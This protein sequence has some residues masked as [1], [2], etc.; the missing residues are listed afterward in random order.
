MKMRK[1]YLFILLSVSYILKSQDFHWTKGFHGTNQMFSR[2]ITTDNMGNVYTVGEF[3]GTVDFNGGVGT[4]TLSTANSDVFITKYDNNGNFIW[5]KNF[6]GGSVEEVSIAVDNLNNLYITGGFSGTVDFDP[7]TSINNQISNGGFDIYVVKLNSSGNFIW[8]KKIGGTNNE[9]G[10]DIKVSSSIFI[11]GKYAG[12]VDFDPGSS[13]INMTSLGNNDVFVLKLDLNGNYIWIKSMGGTSEDYGNSIILDAF[14]NVYTTGLFNN[15]ADFNPGA[16]VYNLVSNNIYSTFISKLDANGNFVWAKSVT[17]TGSQNIGTS[18]A[19]DTTGN[20]FIA[21]YFNGTF[22]FDSGA[23]TYNIT[24]APSGGNN[25]FILKLNINGDF[26]WA[27]NLTGYSSTG[28][29]SISINKKGY[30]FLTSSFNGS[31]DFDPSASVYSLT[32]SG[33]WDS[34]VTKLNNNGNFIW[35]KKFNGASND[36]NMAKSIALDDN[37]D[38]FT[39]G[40]FSGTTDFD[41]TPNTVNL[42]SIGFYDTYVVKLSSCTNLSSVKN[43]TTCVNYISPSGN[44][45]WTTSGTYHD[46]IA[47]AFGCDS[48]ITVNLTFD[49]SSA[50]AYTTNNM[51]ATFSITGTGCNTFLW[52]FGNGNTSSINPNPVI[53]YASPGTYGVCLQCNGQPTNCV[54]CINITVPSNTGSGV[55]IEEHQ[56]QTDDLFSPNPTNEI[57]HIKANQIVNKGTIE[58]VNLQGQT[59]Y[60]SNKIEEQ[61]NLSNQAKGVYFIQLVTEQNTFTKKII[62]Q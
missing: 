33:T 18:L 5:A 54:K 9:K 34:Y 61:I 42:T 24:S 57:I 31:V 48:T 7:G 11:T 32:S 20:L 35:A 29:N 23:G 60:K 16:S 30:L 27:K 4:T 53:T 51:V 25:A 37:G 49:N 3:F 38:I 41:P 15:T 36:V 1:I 10:L 47:S 14:D 62:L 39:T 40:D 59:I 43:V 8:S 45:T 52:D 28:F 44:Y 58:I 56:N 50:F 2:D 6:R 46:T 12:T 19:I 22:D 21:G 55:G 13:A 26:V 17:G